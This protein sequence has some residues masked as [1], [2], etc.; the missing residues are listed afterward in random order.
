MVDSFLLVLH[1]EMLLYFGKHIYFFVISRNDNRLFICS[2]DKLS[3]S[4]HDESSE[5]ISVSKCSEMGQ[6]YSLAFY[7]GFLIVGTSGI[8]SGYTWCDKTQKLLKKSWTIHLPI[9]PEAR[10]MDEVNDLWVDNEN[11]L[12]FAGCGDNNIYSCSLEGGT[13]VR[14]FT[15]HSDYIHS[16]DGK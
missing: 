12:L 11:N 15:G 10:E 16:I 2:I 9:G 14:K 1:L 3:T 4:P 8:I 7:S 6:I 5:P 13:I